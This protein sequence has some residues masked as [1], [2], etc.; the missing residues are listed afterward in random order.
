MAAQL[1]MLET[2]S[3]VERQNFQAKDGRNNPVGKLERITFHVRS[4]ESKQQVWLKEESDKE[5]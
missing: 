4:R 5:R 3:L 2:Q 1:E